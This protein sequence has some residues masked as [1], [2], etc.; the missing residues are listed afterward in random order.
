MFFPMNKKEKPAAGSWIADGK[1]LANLKIAGHTAAAVIE[2]RRLKIFNALN[3]LRLQYRWAD[4][5]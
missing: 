4:A 1:P 2:L 5:Q 3:N